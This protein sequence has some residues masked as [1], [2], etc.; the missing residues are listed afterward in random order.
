MNA[1]FPIVLPNVWLPS[2]PVIDVMDAGLRDNYG[3]ETTLRFL[4]SFDDWLEKNT[5][6]VLIIQIRDRQA[7]GWEAPYEADNISDHFVKPFLLLQ[8]NWYKLM[9]Y[10]QNDML[11]YYAESGHHHIHK[12]VFQ[13]ASDAAEN[14]AALN[15]HLTQSEK[16]NILASVKSPLNAKSFQD[17]LNELK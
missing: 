14:K 8:H 2:D 4:E 3:E 7:G 10:F 16:L 9:E 11:E 12:I 17:V 15:F 13:Y 5:S 6:G 1:T